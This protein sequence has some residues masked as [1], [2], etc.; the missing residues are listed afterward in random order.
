MLDG[1]ILVAS[2]NSAL[3][4]QVRRSL[5]DQSWPVQEVSGG[6][7]AL[8]K[9]ES[10]DWQVL[11]LDRRLPDLD[12]EE[13]IQII[14]ARFPG[15]RVVMLDSDGGPIQQVSALGPSGFRSWLNPQIS[16]LNDDESARPRLVGK[17]ESSSAEVPPLPGMIGS[18]EKMHRLYRLTRLVAPRNTTV[19]I[20]GA[21]GTGKELV[22]RAVHQLSSRS[23]AAFVVVNCAAIPETLLESELFGFSRGAFT[24]AVQ[25]YAGRIHAAQGGTLFL[26]EIGEM[27]LSLQAKLLR[28][29]EQKEVQRLGSS[30]PIRVDVRVV[31]ATNAALERQVE[32]A[33][34]R[35]DLYYPL[36][37]FPLELPVLA[38]R[39]RDI[40]PLAQHFLKLAVSGY[41]ATSPALSEEAIRRLESH[42]WPG[43]VRELQQV[44]ERAAIMA[45]GADTIRGQ[46]L[47]FSPIPGNQFTQEKSAGWRPS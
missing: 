5:H 20:L 2:P 23:E 24:G 18:S 10:G 11:F 21:T 31:A 34:F 36:S 7:D 9:L 29:L 33:R 40:V 25:A 4:E 14:K 22:A 27:P 46:H 17:A 19:L 1:G 26:D 15:I 16:D 42:S 30:D 41:R 8:V 35:Q 44:I 39:R 45:D 3:R 37:A 47:H 13:V 38:E 43:N 6:A 12:A 32:A 28:F